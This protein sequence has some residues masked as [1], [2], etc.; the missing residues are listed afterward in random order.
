MIS[1][2]LAAVR[3]TQTIIIRAWCRDQHTLSHFVARFCSVLLFVT[4]CCTLLLY[5]A[6]C[7][8]MLHYVILYY[9]TLLCTLQPVL[10]AHLLLHIFVPL[11]HLQNSK[12][13]CSV[14]HCTIM[15]AFLLSSLFEM[16]RRCAV[17][18]GCCLHLRWARPNTQCTVQVLLLSLSDNSQ[19][20]CIQMHHL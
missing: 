17:H 15:K 3:V 13:H 4:L 10:C 11:D 6:L 9:T 2:E 5:V 8:S 20:F 19:D 16:A 12:V 14:L 18:S 7:Y 1:I